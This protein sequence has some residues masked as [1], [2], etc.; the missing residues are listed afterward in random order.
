MSMLA[1]GGQ[2]ICYGVSAGGPATFDSVLVLRTRLTVSGLAMFSEINRETAG[3]GLGRLARMVAAGALK[4][5]IAVEAPWT[6]IGP[7]ARQLL[8]RAYRGKAVLLVS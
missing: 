7:V 4:P 6:D 1:P 3:V 2:I 8:D 5:L